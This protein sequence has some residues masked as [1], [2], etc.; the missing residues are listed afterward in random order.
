MNASSHLKGSLLAEALNLNDR[1][2]YVTQHG[3]AEVG[4][5]RWIGKLPENGNAL[6]TWVGVEF[7]NPVG[8][9]SAWS[10]GKILFTARPERAGLVR[11]EELVKSEDFFCLTET[12]DPG[13]GPDAV[14]GSDCDSI[15]VGFRGN[16]S[17]DL[18]S[19]LS[20]SGLESSGEDSGQQSRVSAPAA[21]RCGTGVAKCSVKAGGMRKDGK[22]PVEEHPRVRTGI[23]RRNAT[24]PSQN[25]D[26]GASTADMSLP[27][28][29]EQ[30][31][32][33]A[34]LPC[35]A[36]RHGDIMEV[37]SLVEVFGWFKD[38]FYGVIRW[39]GY[40]D[41]QDLEGQLMTG[42]EME[43]EDERFSDGVFNGKRYFYCG[44]Q[45]ALF[46]PL[47]KCQRDRRFSSSSSP[48]P[49]T[50]LNLEADCVVPGIVAPCQ[51]SDRLC[52][53]YRGIQGHLNSCYL[54]ATLFAMFTYSCVFDSVLYRPPKACDIEEYS[55][56]QAILREEIVNPLRK[57]CYVKAN[58]VMRLRCLL[59]RCS[60]VEGLVSE[61]KGTF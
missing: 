18:I 27:D 49:S 31:L 60:R 61:E 22:S 13:I 53:P 1:V 37:G 23:L 50:S 48:R 3:A 19:F 21:S 17:S 30:S 2:V 54:D 14:Y 7:D 44:P 16:G 43:E 52:G 10:D 4:S 59:D 26:V 57:F 35:G 15:N 42:L 38:V 12:N 56:L 51:T 58:H 32:L 29:P 25:E 36:T 8:Q 28:S 9:D 40:I 39:I 11:I 55:E 46:L 24:L 45:R 34:T 20:C 41:D 5:V 33:P 6:R 47:A